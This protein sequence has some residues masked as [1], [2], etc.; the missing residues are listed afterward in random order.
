MID[1]TARLIWSL[2]GA[3]LTSSIAANGN[4]GAIALDIGDVTDVWLAVY[5]AG[6][7]TG[8]SPTLDVQL[9]VRDPTGNWF[10]QVMKVTQLTSGPG[11]ASASAGLHIAGNGSVVLPRH[12][13]VAWTVGGTTPVFPQTSISLYGR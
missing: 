13:R 5:V 8:T 10:P 1:N 7:S 6:T 12:C 2:S 4:S 9:D 11:C 3:G